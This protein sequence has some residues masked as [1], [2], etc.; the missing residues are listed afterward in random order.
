MDTFFYLAVIFVVLFFVAVVI[1]ALLLIFI[2]IL[3]KKNNDLKTVAG[4]TNPVNAAVPAMNP[5]PAANPTPVA[6]PTPIATP[7][8]VVTPEPIVTPASAVTPTP[9]AAPTPIV[10]PTP[11]ATPPFVVDSAPAITPT[12]VVTPELVET[13]M[14][15]VNPETV[16]TPIPI[17]NLTNPVE[18]T[19]AQSQQPVHEQS[20]P[21]NTNPEITFTN[22]NEQNAVQQKEDSIPATV[23]DFTP[24]QNQPERVVSS[25]KQ[26]NNPKTISIFN[27]KGNRIILEQKDNPGICYTAIFP[28][29]PIGEIPGGTIV[30]G[31]EIGDIL[32]NDGA[33]S[34]THCTIIRVGSDFYLKDNESS[35]HTYYN[36][37]EIT[38]QTRI[39]SGG[40][41]KIGKH[42]YILRIEE[43]QNI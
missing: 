26:K 11:V 25:P 20:E 21:N 6:V 38:Q 30:V 35:N 23:M 17:A 12:P 42:E 4:N 28:A 15:V 33:V 36:D 5:T 39:F 2:F 1:I 9:V 16:E 37:M 34:A 14:P 29:T 7:V 32:I 10:T 31:R 8:P 41:L 18:N 3:L 13:P 19:M 24:V 27:T 43:G 22:S 40:I